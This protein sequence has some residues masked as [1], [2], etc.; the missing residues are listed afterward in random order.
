METKNINNMETELKNA[1][2]LIKNKLSKEEQVKS[3]FTNDKGDVD[4]MNL[5]LPGLHLYFNGIT[6][7]AIFNNDQEAGHII[8]DGQKAW[9]L[10]NNKQESEKSISNTYQK[11]KE[12]YNSLQI[13]NKIY[14]YDQKADEFVIN[15]D[16]KETT[17]T[18]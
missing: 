14:N 6:A 16:S 17:I 13:A 9:V 11:S 5:K 2:E 3:L 18:K 4:L 12:V 8:N 15:E 1:L 7:E 10:T